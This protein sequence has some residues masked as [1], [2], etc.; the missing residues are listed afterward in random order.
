MHARTLIVAVSTA[1]FMSTAA[2]AASMSPAQCRSESGSSRAT[3]PLRV[4]A[5]GQGVGASVRTVG[6]ACGFIVDANVTDADERGYD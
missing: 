3:D 6:E 1:M 5:S 2:F 4:T